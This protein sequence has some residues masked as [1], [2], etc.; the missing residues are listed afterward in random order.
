MHVHP[1]VC[2][3]V[4][5][6]SSLSPRSTYSYLCEA[7]RG[8][9]PSRGRPWW[10]RRRRGRPSSWLLQSYAGKTYC[11][12]KKK[13]RWDRTT[14]RRNEVEGRLKRGSA[15]KM[16]IWKN[17]YRCALKLRSNSITDQI[18][19][20]IWV[21]SWLLPEQPSRR[22]TAW[23]ERFP[24]WRAQTLPTSAGFRYGCSGMRLC[25]LAMPTFLLNV[26]QKCSY[27]DCVHW[28]C[29]HFYKCRSD[30]FIQRLCSLTMPTFLLNVV[31]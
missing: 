10:R 30:M 20:S 18:L 22:D 19:C 14:Y 5:T 12:V 3:S 16:V 28:L 26:V 25:S 4:I 23:G 1:S 2:L 11:M 13:Y 17:R 7:C 9:R 29:L 15:K 21:L 27:R 31:Q 24:G 8:R 6:V